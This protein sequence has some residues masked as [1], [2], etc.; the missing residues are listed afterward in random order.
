[1]GTVFNFGL[2]GILAALNRVTALQSPR[3]LYHRRQVAM[4]AG[5]CILAFFC[6]ADLA[7]AVNYS[8]AA[9]RYEEL[10]GF[11]FAAVVATIAA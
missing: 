3:Q 7:L 2:Y 10:S 8:N 4:L 5:F 6:V 1:M 9:R 11:E